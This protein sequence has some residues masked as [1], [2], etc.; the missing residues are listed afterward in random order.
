MHGWDTYYT[1]SKNNERDILNVLLYENTSATSSTLVYMR[2][3]NI[4]FNNWTIVYNDEEKY[5]CEE[6]AA[7][8]VH[9]SKILKEHMKAYNSLDDIGGWFIDALEKDSSTVNVVEK[10]KFLLN[11]AYNTSS[12]G[13]INDEELKSLYTTSSESINIPEGG[14]F[15]AIAQACH[16]YLRLN[17]YY[18]SS[19]AN[20]EAGNYIQDGTS[21]GRKLPVVLGEPQDKRYID[22]SAYVT[23][24]LMQ[25]GHIGEKNTKQYSSRM[26]YA[27][28][29][30]FE[31]MEVSE[32]DTI[33]DSD[34]NTNL[35]IIVKNGHTEIYAGKDENGY[36]CTY[37]AG[38]TSSIRKEVSRY[39]REQFY[40]H[41]NSDYKILIAGEV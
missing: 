10:V 1:E 15:L 40:S 25:T 3:N 31:E 32:V 12:F 33:T 6:S 7:E 27:N 39:T 9:F 23:W 34:L 11:Q 35:Y 14:S 29:W 8:N 19:G 24:V 36:Y 18:Y 22:C 21:L 17:K 4:N 41:F 13:E 26:L 5:I 16:D 38:S 20:I 28:S 30:G 37:N 2:D